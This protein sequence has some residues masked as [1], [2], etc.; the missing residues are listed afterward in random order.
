M[1]KIPILKVSLDLCSILRY[2]NILIGNTQIVKKKKRFNILCSAKKFLQ[3]WTFQLNIYKTGDHQGFYS[4]P[5]IKGV[6][7]F[8]SNVWQSHIFPVTFYQISPLGVPLVPVCF[9]SIGSFAL[10]NF[11]KNDKFHLVVF[12][13][14]RF[15]RL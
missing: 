14:S 13:L 10:K 9:A 15:K 7:R 11:D 12:L 6:S 3:L 4:C 8:F 5:N 2:L 1:A